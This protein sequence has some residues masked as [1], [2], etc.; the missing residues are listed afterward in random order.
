MDDC[1]TWETLKTNEIIDS[2]DFKESENL[3]ILCFPITSKK[4]KN[5]FE[6][7]FNVIE[8]LNFINVKITTINTSLENKFL[9]FFEDVEYLNLNGYK[10]SDLNG[11]LDL[12]NMVNLKR[13]ILK[14]DKEMDIFYPPNLEKLEIVNSDQL[15]SLDNDRVIKNILSCLKRT[16]LKLKTI[17]FPGGENTIQTLMRLSGMKNTPENIIMNKCKDKDYTIKRL[18]GDSNSTLWKILNSKSE[19]IKEEFTSSGQT[20]SVELL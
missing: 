19:K 20:L 1:V 17:K 10:S 18:A 6:K 7:N 4:Q 16:N 15:S 12:S 14:L 8:T 9:K 5:I 3:Y 13:L 2:D 11:T